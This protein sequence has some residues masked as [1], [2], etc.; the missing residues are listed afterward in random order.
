MCTYFIIGDYVPRKQ[1]LILE[2]LGLKAVEANRISDVMVSL[3]VQGLV[4][5]RIDKVTTIIFACKHLSLPVFCRGLQQFYKPLQ[6]VLEHSV[7]KLL[8]QVK[9]M[10]LTK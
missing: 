2:K 8:I 9:I 7:D 3:L 1:S 6:S 10:H 5:L 4:A